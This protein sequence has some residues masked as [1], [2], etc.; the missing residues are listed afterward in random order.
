MNDTSSAARALAAALFD[1][2]LPASPIALWT[3][4]R[5]AHADWALA[6]ACA[7]ADI[8]A[9]LERGD[10]DSDGATTGHIDRCGEHYEA[11]EDAEAR[12]G[13]IIQDL[14]HRGLLDEIGQYL[15]V[16]YRG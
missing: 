9:M 16:T 7:H 8:D 13:E 11:M 1:P 2:P 15:A 10:A 12:M 14:A 4:L 6:K 3:D 5:E